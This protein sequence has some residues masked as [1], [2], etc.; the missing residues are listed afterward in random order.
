[1]T[2]PTGR[3][4]GRPRIYRSGAEV[5]ALRHMKKRAYLSRHPDKLAAWRM[6]LY[7][8]APNVGKIVNER[9]AKHERKEGITGELGKPVG[10]RP[11]GFSKK[12]W[13]GAGANAPTSTLAEG[14]FYRPP[15]A[16]REAFAYDME[17]TVRQFRRARD[18]SPVIQFPER[19]NE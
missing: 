18:R 14:P 7:Q 19:T 12:K 4:R 9:K 13:A 6:R 3:P 16:Y 10:G 11:S 5:R 15:P 8:V 1:M 17:R 2:K